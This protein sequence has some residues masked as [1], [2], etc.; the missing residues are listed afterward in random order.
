MDYVALI[1]LKQTIE[2]LLNSSYISITS[3]SIKILDSAYKE[4]NSL[5]EN[6]KKLDRN[7]SS[8]ETISALDGKLSQAVSNFE[9][10]LETHVSNQFLKDE[11][12]PTS[13]SVDLQGLKTDIDF[14]RRAARTM[15]KAYV[16]GLRSSESEEDNDIY[17]RS[18]QGMIGLSDEFRVTIDRLRHWWEP[19]I[20]AVSLVGMAGIGKTTLSMEIFCDDFISEYFEFRAWVRVGP[21][22][23]IKDIFLGVI[24]E[25]KDN[26]EMRSLKGKRYLIVLDDVWDKKVWHEFKK[27][28]PDGNTASR[29]LLTTRLEEVAHDASDPIR[30]IT[31]VPF[32]DKEESWHLLRAKVFG[33]KPCPRS[34]E[35]AGKKIAEN[36]EGLPLLIV[37]VADVLSKSK[38]KTPEY[39]KEVAERK[40]SVFKDANDQVSNVL[41]PSYN[42][43]PQHL[44]ACFL[45]I[46]VFPQ[47]QEILV[48]TL[49]KLWGSE[50][51]LEPNWWNT[52]EDL[53]M[54]CVEDLV[55][56]NLVIAR[57][58]SSTGRI[59]TCGLHSVFWHMCVGVAAKNK[60][61]GVLNSRADG[62][63]EEGMN[64]QLRL[65]VHN[66]VLFGIKDVYKSME[67]NCASTTRSLVCYGP[68]HQ[69]QVPICFDLR[70]LRVL[71]A[72]TIRFYEFPEKVLKLVQ[73][74]YLALT[75]N[76][77]LP[78]L[79]S[80]LWKLQFLID[81]KELKH[82]QITGCN[83]P[84]PCDD[85]RL[86][87][88]V[89]LLDVSP[90][91]C[92]LDILGRFPNLKKLGVQIE[93]EPNSV[94][95]PL[96]FFDQISHL[97]FLESLKCV[98]VNPKCMSQVTDTPCSSAI[99][100][101]GLKKLSLSGFGY[102][103]GYMRAIS[104]LPNLEVLKLRCY[105]FQGA[106]WE[107]REGEFVQ[108][109]FLL[110]EDTDLMKWRVDKG[111]FM[112]LQHL[113][114]RHCYKL[115][116]IPLGFNRSRNFNTIELVDCSPAA[117]GCAKKM[118]KES[119]HL[120]GYVHC[121]W[122]NGNLKS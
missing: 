1:S 12:H 61:F 93:V 8:R 22:R 95:P 82:L 35:K 87:N 34:L 21:K 7:S 85:R 2:R 99:F 33:D 27:L 65:C 45:Y 28:F 67:I 121:S 88:V 81:M 17:V 43:L 4:V 116:E 26:D 32:M 74:R 59:K 101:P 24:A 103:W 80:K 53:S 6:L 107:T 49:V 90:Q 54:S 5:Q 110:L 108:L 44:K 11:N 92:T 50:R 42:Y 9:D 25:M 15:K 3:P 115:V 96:R 60:F 112:Q 71:D 23:G 62:L 56:R 68:P 83:L 48:S 119:Y 89:K 31:N 106:E 100:P 77:N 79:I 98:V 69:Y 122:E 52:L 39:W 20:Q 46:G 105:A 111:C 18:D 16:D 10:V 114:I 73:L 91:S 57:Q 66:N 113:V 109:K 70:L 86:Q 29:V 76:G 47:N 97:H 36:C 19:E 30:R 37:T 117:I 13:F 94:E 14:F 102:S 72:L 58:K 118:M 120:K 38:N 40:N 51:F 78:R 64:S 55:S 84:V 41:F 75:C 63:S 104:S